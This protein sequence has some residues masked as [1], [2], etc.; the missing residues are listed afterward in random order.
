M[1]DVQTAHLEVEIEIHLKV[2]GNDGLVQNIIV[3]ELRTSQ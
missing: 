2:Y 3:S 1:N